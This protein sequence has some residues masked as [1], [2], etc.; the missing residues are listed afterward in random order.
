MENISPLDKKISFSQAQERIAALQDSFNR[1]L[2]TV[3]N[4][5]E[6]S[7]I[8]PLITASCSANLISGSSISKEAPLYANLIRRSS[9]GMT[10]EN[11]YADSTT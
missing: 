3:L 6:E 8:C 10:A 11:I 7:V 1:E 2:I 4:N 5:C 9:V